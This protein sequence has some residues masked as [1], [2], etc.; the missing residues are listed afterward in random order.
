MLPPNRVSLRDIILPG[1][2]R[3]Q[4]RRAYRKKALKTH[5]DKLPQD[6]SEEERNVA[7]EKFREVG[8][9]Y[10][11]YSILLSASVADQPCLRDIDRPRKTQSMFII[12][13]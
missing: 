7:A 4:V 13:I 11:L 9:Y 5:P 8:L 6:L 12:I 1:P 10:E 3:S 2:D